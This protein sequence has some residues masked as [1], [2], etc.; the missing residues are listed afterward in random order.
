MLKSSTNV[1]STGSL[2][3]AGETTDEYCGERAWSRMEAQSG[4]EVRQLKVSEISDPYVLVPIAINDVDT[5]MA[6]QD[7]DVT[8]GAAGLK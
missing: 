3:L 4:L 6:G 2:A 8:E 7:R 1:T 5:S